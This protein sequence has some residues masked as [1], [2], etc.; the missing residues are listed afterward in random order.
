MPT[1]KKNLKNIRR[2][3]ITKIIENNRRIMKI[4]MN[5][6]TKSKINKDRSMFKNKK[7]IIKIHTK[8]KNILKKQTFMINKFIRHKVRM[9]IN[10]IRKTKRILEMINNSKK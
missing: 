5:M 7:M 1:N 2:K 10:L 8:M 3:I 9:L 4:V 6:M